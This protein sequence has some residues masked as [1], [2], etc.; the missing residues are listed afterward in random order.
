MKPARSQNST[1]TTRRSSIPAAAASA[2]PHRP[3]NANPSGTSAP[4]DGQFNGVAPATIPTRRAAARSGDA[5]TPVPCLAALPAAAAAPILGAGVAAT[6]AG[7]PSAWAVERNARREEIR[8][9]E[10]DRA[11]LAL[12]RPVLVVRR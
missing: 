10:P 12:H 5:C 1:V 2:A 9:G 7:A 4:Q 6:R 3:Q 8:H 11:R